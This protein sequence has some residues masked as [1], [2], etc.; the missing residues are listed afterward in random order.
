MHHLSLKTFI[1]FSF[2]TCATL[3]AQPNATPEMN[4]TILFQR[5]NISV[6]DRDI[7]AALSQFT[8]H[9]RWMLR[10]NKN[11]I[12]NII[13]D[14]FTNKVAYAEQH[15]AILSDPLLKKAAEQELNRFVFRNYV[16]QQQLKRSEG[17]DFENMA[18]VNW[19][20]H[21]EK[22]MLAADYDVYHILFPYFEHATLD[23]KTLK[24][25]AQK[26]LR[27]IDKGRI[28]FADAAA[29]YVTPLSGTDEQGRIMGITTGKL[30]PELEKAV[31]QLQAG[32]HTP[33]LESSYGFHIFQMIERRPQRLQAF[34]GDL[35]KELIADAN[36]Q[37][38]RNIQKEILSQYNNDQGVTFNDQALVNYIT[39][40]LSRND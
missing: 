25:N 11:S 5:G 18:E 21:Q 36:E 14:I 20:T 30:L 32:E 7:D 16:R 4:E 19:K 13:E 15:A 34:S 33:V 27:R 8:Q 10:Q 24:K 29:R 23:K 39:D 26:L 22:Y 37:H 2:F 40:F 38:A 31:A 28:T 1:I 3:Q 12:T 9:E 6:T 17:I 35:K